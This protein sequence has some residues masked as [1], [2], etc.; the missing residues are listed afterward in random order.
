MSSDLGTST[1]YRRPTLT[2]IAPRKLVKQL[3]LLFILKWSFLEP[4][5]AVSNLFL[6]FRACLQHTR[7][8]RKSPFGSICL[9]MLSNCL[10]IT[11]FGFVRKS[12]CGSI[13]L[14][15]AANCSPLFVVQQKQ[16]RS[17]QFNFDNRLRSH[18]PQHRTCQTQSFGSILAV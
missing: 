11:L 14:C 8:L 4:E 17:A 5:V 10:R 12:P 1:L 18:S 13:C 7:L 16:L 3:F 6:N 9:R 15:I 2:K